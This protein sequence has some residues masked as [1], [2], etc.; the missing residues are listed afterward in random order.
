MVQ[1]G[2]ILTPNALNVN[3]GSIKMRSVRCSAK[4]KVV[5]LV[6]EALIHPSFDLFEDNEAE[7]GF[8]ILKATYEICSSSDDAHKGF[9]YIPITMSLDDENE[10]NGNNISGG[11]SSMM[12]MNHNVD[13]NHSSSSNANI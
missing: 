2:G 12:M 8:K 1:Q 13:T 9:Q 7:D 6:T 5:F 4:V 10:D 3:L 11:D